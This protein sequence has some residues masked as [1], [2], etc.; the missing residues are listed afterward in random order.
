MDYLGLANELRRALVTYTEKR[1]HGADR[2]RQGRGGGSD[3]GE[4]RGLLR[5]VPRLRLVEVDDSS[6]PGAL[7]VAPLGT[8]ACPSPRERQSTAASQAVR[9][10]S[11]AFALAVP[12][13]ETFRIRDD[14]GFFQQVR[15]ALSKR[16]EAGSAS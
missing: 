8:G 15:A 4:A 1:G 12:H 9:E 13:E 16:S 6:G 14:V 3:A 10:L 5:P 7:A 2:H 11:Q